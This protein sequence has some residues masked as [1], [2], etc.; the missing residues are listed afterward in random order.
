MSISERVLADLQ[1]VSGT[2]EV[3]K[4]LDLLLFDEGVLDS[5]AT[6]ELMLLFTQDFGIQISPAQFDRQQWATPRKMIAYIDTQVG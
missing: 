3:R 2:D 5:F 4:D 1:K 6:L